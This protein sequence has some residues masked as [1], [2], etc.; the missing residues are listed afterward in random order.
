MKKDANFLY[1][2]SSWLNLTELPEE[3]TLVISLNTKGNVLTNS[4]LDNLIL[5]QEGISTVCLEGAD[6]MPEA[7]SNIAE[8]INKMYDLKVCWYTNNE[9]NLNAD[10]SNLNYIKLGDYN[11]NTVDKAFKIKNSKLINITKKLKQYGN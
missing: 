8:Y 5:Y 11:N 3:I 6:D 4:A 2:K 1:Y 9:D 10:L 7:I